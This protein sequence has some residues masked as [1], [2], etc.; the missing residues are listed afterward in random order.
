MF[1]CEHIYVAFSTTY[2]GYLTLRRKSEYLR[3]KKI[4]CWHRSI[5]AQQVLPQ[6]GLIV[7]KGASTEHTTRCLGSAQTVL[8]RA[9]EWSRSP[10]SWIH[11]MSCQEMASTAEA[12]VPGVW[13]D[14]P[15]MPWKNRIFLKKIWAMMCHKCWCDPAPALLVSPELD[16]KVQWSTQIWFLIS[17]CRRF[18]GPEAVRA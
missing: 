13:C 15:A 12:G 17:P 2:I 14:Q 7:W 3:R 1:W 16:F 18:P 10:L 8:P 9:G 5:W 4:S 11:D 6:Y